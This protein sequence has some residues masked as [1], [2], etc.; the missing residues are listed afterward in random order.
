MDDLKYERVVKRVKQ[1]KDFHNHLKIFGVVN[2]FLFLLKGNFLSVFIPKGVL[3]VDPRYYDWVITNFI[4]WGVIIV[5][6]AFF[7]FTNKLRFFKR[8]ENRQIEKYIKKDKE[9]GQKYF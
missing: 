1:L 6:H 8:W 3:V 9:E 4:L 2:I 5:I 7:V